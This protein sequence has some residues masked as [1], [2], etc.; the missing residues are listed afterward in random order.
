MAQKYN[1]NVVFALK[2]GSKYNKKVVYDAL[3]GGSK[4]N[5]KVVYAQKYNNY[6]SNVSTYINMSTLCQN[7]IHGHETVM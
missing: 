1:K 3:W 2:V 4:Y 5:K 7:I 6:K